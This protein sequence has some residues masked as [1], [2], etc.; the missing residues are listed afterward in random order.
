MAVSYN[1]L[2]KYSI[3]KSQCFYTVFLLF[4]DGVFF[5]MRLYAVNNYVT[6]FQLLSLWSISS[7]CDTCVAFV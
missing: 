3:S 2:F 4:Y 5:S 6:I 1:R 7:Y